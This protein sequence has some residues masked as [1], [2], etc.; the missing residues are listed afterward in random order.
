MLAVTTCASWTCC[1]PHGC[2]GESRGGSD[3]G[4]QERLRGHLSAV[5]G[6]DEGDLSY[7][8]LEV[9][10]AAVKPWL[11]RLSGVAAPTHAPARAGLSR[12]V[13]RP[14]QPVLQVEAEPA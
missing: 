1:A 12:K 3:V 13:V 4:A 10:G 6:L 8:R 11:P 2:S 7:V 14:D 9:R 5:V